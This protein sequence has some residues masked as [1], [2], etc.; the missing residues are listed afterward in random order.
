MA[1]NNNDNNNNENNNNNEY[2]KILEKFLFVRVL[3]MPFF[4]YK[5]ISFLPGL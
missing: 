3:N 2:K 4:E 5:K 1:I